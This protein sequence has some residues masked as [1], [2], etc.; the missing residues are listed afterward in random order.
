MTQDTLSSFFGWL[1]LLHV[2]T[3]TLA[4]VLTLLLQD[5]V[6]N[7]HARMF[8]LPAADVRRV[9]YGWLGTYKLLIFVTALGPWLALQLI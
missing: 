6:A 8:G 2:A 9:I 4:T 7:L 1:S 3:L 5:F